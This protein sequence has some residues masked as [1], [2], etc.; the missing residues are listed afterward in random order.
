MDQG[1]IVDMGHGGARF[2]SS[3][4]RGRPFK[5]LLF[6][7]KKPSEILPI[8]VFRCSECGYVE[9]YAREE[10]EAKG[11]EKQFSLRSLL[12]FVT[13]VAFVLGVYTV[14]RAIW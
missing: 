13:A 9:S 2:V 3:W 14:L 6:G 4:A 5:L 8:G 7:V 12:I 10:F 1:F 11:Q